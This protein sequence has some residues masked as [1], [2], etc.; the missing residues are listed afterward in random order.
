MKAII[1][2]LHEKHADKNMDEVLD[3]HGLKSNEAQKVLDI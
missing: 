2:T 3:L 1:R